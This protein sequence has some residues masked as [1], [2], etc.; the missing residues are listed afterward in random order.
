MARMDTQ[1]ATRVAAV[2]VTLGLTFIAGAAAGAHGGSF[3]SANGG[4]GEEQCYQAAQ[5]GTYEQW[6]S[7]CQGAETVNTET[8]L[9]TEE[10]VLSDSQATQIADQQWS[11][12]WSVHVSAPDGSTRTTCEVAWDILKV[13]RRGKT[14]ITADQETID[15]LTAVSSGYRANVRQATADDPVLV[16]DMM[17]CVQTFI[18]KT[19]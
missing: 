12:V 14:P 15:L 17:T 19:V 6:S 8:P 7:A 16:E 9:A 11:Q 1:R 5:S 3:N 2:A 13:S 10:V 4:D 18:G